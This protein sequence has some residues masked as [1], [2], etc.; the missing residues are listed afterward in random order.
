MKVFVL[1]LVSKL[2]FAEKF[3]K[4]NH[5]NFFQELIRI[6]LKRASSPMLLEDIQY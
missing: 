4:Q 3:L 1:V 2:K 5:K 6:N